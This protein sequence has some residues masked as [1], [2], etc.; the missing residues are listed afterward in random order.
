MTS[1]TDDDVSLSLGA[2][3]PKLGEWPNLRRQFALL[4]RTVVTRRQ[5]AEA[6]DHTL[7]D[8][9]ISRADAMAEA[10]RAPWCLRPRRPSR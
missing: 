5:L 9:G 8:I 6:D 3:L 4:L 10:R 7:R 2:A 1:R